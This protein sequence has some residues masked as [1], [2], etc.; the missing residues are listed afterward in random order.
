M[1]RHRHI[2]LDA[3]EYHRD[4]A[5]VEI[6]R[7]VL[8]RDRCDRAADMRR[9][10]HIGQRAQPSLVRLEQ[11]VDR[12]H[13]KF[14]DLVFRKGDA[15]DVLLR[16]DVRHLD[17]KR[18]AQ[19]SVGGYVRLSVVRNEYR[20]DIALIAE[21]DHPFGIDPPRC[22]LR[23]NK[24]E[25]AYYQHGR[26]NSLRLNMHET[27]PRNEYEQREID[28][29]QIPFETEFYRR[30]AYVRARLDEQYHRGEEQRN[31]R[32]HPA[33][34]R[35]ERY[36][37]RDQKDGERERHHRHHHQI[38]KHEYERRR[39]ER[40]HGDGQHAYVRRDRNRQRRRKRL[41]AMYA[42]KSALNV[43]I[44]Q[45]YP[46][47]RGIAHQKSEREQRV[48][49]KDQRRRRSKRQRRQRVVSASDDLTQLQNDDHHDRADYRRRK[50][51]DRAESEQYR[52]Q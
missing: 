23:H 20:A 39:A 46:V 24:H 22:G 49:R 4:T 21:T 47:D 38:G 15:I 32:Q 25:K 17:Q 51:A 8:V 52:Y 7:R 16:Q 35:N 50:P 40:V 18:I 44:E 10:R 26:Q 31:R 28:D 48:R 12:I 19:V 11:A 36:H 13:V 30:N 3:A 27:E 9:L 14:V 43:F 42:D 33:H 1:R 6:Y 2:C 41:G 29:E 5:V 45:H 34:I 37:K